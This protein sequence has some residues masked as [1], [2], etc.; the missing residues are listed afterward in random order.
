MHRLLVICAVVWAA[1][2]R[3]QSVLW[4]FGCIRV[5]S[6]I[7]TLYRSYRMHGALLLGCFGIRWLGVCL[8]GCFEMA[9]DMAGHLQTDV[10]RIISHAFGCF[11]MTLIG[12]IQMATDMAGLVHTDVARLVWH[13]W[14]S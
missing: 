11:D 6:K 5:L 12:C 13:V 8:V 14:V 4:Q 10:A 1:V 2:S 9:V 7:N 3:R